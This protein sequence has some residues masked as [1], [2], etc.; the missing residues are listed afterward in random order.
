MI[1]TSDKII[2]TTLML[3]LI[4]IFSTLGQA[5]SLSIYGTNTASF[6]ELTVDGFIAM[7]ALSLI[8]LIGYV[9]GQLPFFKKAP[10]ILW[11]SLISA[12]ISSPAFP[13]SGYL[14]EVT[15]GISMLAISVPLLAYVGLGLGN[16]IEQFKAISWRILPVA[17]AILT[18]TFLF[19]AIFA[20][21]TLRWEGIIP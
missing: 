19:S 3:I 8:A 2:E 20:Q 12:F 4:S 1:K 21:F 15:E 16:E 14:V 17:C 6:L 5:V 13:Y 9:I 18:G 7:V 10:V 11:V